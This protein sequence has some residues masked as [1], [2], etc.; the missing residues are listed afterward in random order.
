M[1][2]AEDGGTDLEGLSGNG[3]GGT[4]TAGYDGLHVDYR[5]PA[6]HLGEA[7]PPPQRS[8]GRPQKRTG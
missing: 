1:A 3:P 5:N 2:F 7:T 6:D 4:L 8:C